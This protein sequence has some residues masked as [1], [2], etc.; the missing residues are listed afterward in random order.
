MWPALTVVVPAYNEEDALPPTAARILAFL[1]AEVADGELIIVD[2]GSSDGTP[3]VVDRLA[4]EHPEVTA[5]HLAKNSGMGAALQAGYA[6]ATR[7][8]ITMLPADGQIDPS[9]LPAFFAAARDE[10]ADLVTSVYKNRRYP[11]HRKILS[12]GLR[13]LTAAIVG[14]RART[15]GTYMVRRD[16]LERLGAR[17]DSFMLNL[18]IPIR[19]RRGGYRVA[20]IAIDV[21]DRVAGHSKAAT[22]GRIAHTLRELVALRL[23]IE[24]ERRGA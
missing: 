13:L 11:P 17:S 22:P 19:A 7:D 5:I 8:W 1:R 21:H 2:D 16:V 18:E 15:E 20:T 3:A 14:T 12:V 9:S 10:G 4:A 24:R 23:R 6:A